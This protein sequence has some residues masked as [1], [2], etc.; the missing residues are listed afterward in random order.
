MHLTCRPF[1]TLS[2]T[3]G[4]LFH[5]VQPVGGQ[6]PHREG[7]PVAVSFILT[8]H[9]NDKF[10]AKALL[11]LFRTSQEVSSGGGVQYVVF[12]DASDKPPDLVIR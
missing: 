5:C 1:S 2:S 6:R 12:D 8:T 10:A 4:K 9:N 7:D 11:E 3:E